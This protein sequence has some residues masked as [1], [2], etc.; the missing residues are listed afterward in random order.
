MCAKHNYCVCLKGFRWVTAKVHQCWKFAGL[1]PNTLKPSAHGRLQKTKNS[2]RHNHKAK[3]Q[4]HDKNHFTSANHIHSLLSSVL[5]RYQECTKKPNCH[6]NRLLILKHR[7]CNYAYHFCRFVKQNKT[8]IY[9]SW[10]SGKWL[11]RSRPATPFLAEA[12]CSKNL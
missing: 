9:F 6:K 7:P 5:R 2:T 12:R 1:C 8:K 11:S 10:L 4:K 3:K